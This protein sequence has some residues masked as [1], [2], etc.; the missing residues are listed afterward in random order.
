MKGDKNDNGEGFPGTPLL[1]QGVVVERRRNGQGSPGMLKD[2]P[3]A[4][5]EQRSPVDARQHD[6][7]RGRRHRDR[8]RE[9]DRDA[10]GSPKPGEHPQDDAEH[11][12][13]HH[14]QQIE[15]ARLQNSEAQ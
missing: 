6:D 15:R 8:E 5:P 1:C 7:P 4:P 9:Q 11:D 12:P 10:V 2:G 14:Q 13:D 3:D